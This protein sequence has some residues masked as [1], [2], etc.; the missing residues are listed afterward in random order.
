MNWLNPENQNLPETEYLNLII[1]R[2]FVENSKFL[3]LWNL[4]LLHHWN[5]LIEENK[6][7]DKILEKITQSSCFLDTLS[8][9]YSLSLIKQW[10]E[11]KLYSLFLLQ[12]KF[13]TNKLNW[14]AT[15]FITSNCY[16]AETQ[17][18]QNYYFLTNKCFF[19]KIE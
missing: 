1:S 15:C 4:I 5:E 17:P 16:Q 13:E 14:K 9:A 6:Q 18:C 8:V 11:W 12:L 3:Y 19:F 10:A 2:S 7:K